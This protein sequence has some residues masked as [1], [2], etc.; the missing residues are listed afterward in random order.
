MHNQSQVSPHALFRYITHFQ[1][2]HEPLLPGWLFFY[3]DVVCGGCRRRVMHRKTKGARHG[4]KRNRRKEAKERKIKRK[5]YQGLYLNPISVSRARTR[6]CEGRR[7]ACTC[8]F[9]EA[10]EAAMEIVDNCFGSIDCDFRTWAWY[11]RH[12]DRN[13][14]VDRAYF[15]AS[16]QKCNEILSLPFT[17]IPPV[18]RAACAL[19]FGGSCPFKNQQKSF[20]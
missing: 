15:Y 20:N 10:G 18:Q 5:Q 2:D 16:C 14:I 9:A 6:A 13:R 17:V 3:R 12:F 8:T 1:T 4:Q 7:I 11:C 19:P